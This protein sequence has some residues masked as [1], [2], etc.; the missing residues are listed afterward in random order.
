M[1]KSLTSASVEKHRPD[2]A[3]RREIPD[4]RMPGLYLIVQPSGAK[5]WALRY[6]HNGTA[7]KLTI[8]PYP[9][10]S[11]ADAREQAQQ[12]LNRVQRGGDPAREKRIERRR[13]AE[14]TDDFEAVVRLF[15]ERHAK[16]SNPVPM[17]RRAT[18]IA[19]R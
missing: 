16:P 2:P 11:L 13:N 1:A 18:P 3:R 17:Q 5:S 6:R 15:I 7:R 14:A 9:A 19:A 8:G 10:F 4:G 12:A